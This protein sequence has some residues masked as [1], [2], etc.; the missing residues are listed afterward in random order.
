MCSAECCHTRTKYYE[1][2]QLY[3]IQ[4]RHALRLPGRS[5]FSESDAAA[6]AGGGGQGIQMCPQCMNELT[7]NQSGCRHLDSRNKGLAL[8]KQIGR[9]NPFDLAEFTKIEVPASGEPNEHE[10]CRAASMEYVQCTHCKRWWHWVCGMY[11]QEAMRGLDW[12]C[13][14]CRVEQGLSM[15]HILPEHTAQSLPHTELGDFVETYTNN[16]C[17][18][19]GIEYVPVLV[20]LVSSMQTTSPANHV[21]SSFLSKRG[22]QYPREFPYCSNAL[23]VFQSIDGQDV[24][25]CALYVHEYG[26]E[27]PE[28]NRNRVYV[29]Y[30]DSVR[31]FESLPANKRTVL[32]HSVRLVYFSICFT[33]YFTV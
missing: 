24:L 25:L 5:Y 14:K 13:M 19:A 23:M 10:R 22:Q 9:N 12:Q 30:L 32:Y 6:V 17:K 16:A 31:Y 26:P 29:S 4:C 18:E 15:T 8:Y 33:V 21:L 1:L 20:R 11:N 3:C 28:P 27:C 7:Q 2:Q